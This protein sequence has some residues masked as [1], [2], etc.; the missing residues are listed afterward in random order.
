MSFLQTT[1]SEIRSAV[2][3]YF[4]PLSWIWN[5]CKGIY[6]RL[7]AALSRAPYRSGVLRGTASDMDLQELVDAE[8]GLFL[9][10]GRAEGKRE[11]LYSCRTFASFAYGKGD[12]RTAER[13]LRYALRL[14]MQRGFDPSMNA[15][16]SLDLA[17][18]YTKE[19][20]L[21]EAEL[22][23]DHAVLAGTGSG[24]SHLLAQV[25]LTRGWV[26]HTLGGLE[27]AEREYKRAVNIDVLEGGGVVAA[28]AY[29]NLA[30]ISLE[31]TRLNEARDYLDHAIQLDERLGR[32]R[33]L[34]ENC[35][36]LVLVIEMLG[37]DNRVYQ[38]HETLLKA[39][40]L[41]RK[42]GARLPESLEMSFG[43]E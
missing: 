7:V 20:R 39:A 13:T 34:V 15:E 10:L 43:K 29:A 30:I 12:F 14:S 35:T 24:K 16:L 1:S 6:Q 11:Y 19:G 41:L 26:H 36:R 23:L 28:A 31:R 3:F 27:E 38:I 9:S 5:F 25:L 33:E 17:R 8:R 37:E 32:I 2:E 42:S 40:K 22:L 18:T 21:R 4:E